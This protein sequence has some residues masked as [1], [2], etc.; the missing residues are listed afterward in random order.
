MAVGRFNY[1]R[2]KD[3]VEKSFSLP[4]A[5]ANALL[6]GP[7]TSI[8]QQAALLLGSEGVMLGFTAGGGTPLYLTSVND[9]RPTECMQQWCSLWFD[10]TARLAA[11]TLQRRRISIID[12]AYMKK[13]GKTFRS[14]SKPP[15]RRFTEMGAGF[16][17]RCLSKP[18]A[19]RSSRV[20][21]KVETGRIGPFMLSENFSV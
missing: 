6:L 8:T 4:Y 3:A 15:T 5:N 13:F 19:R 21:R 2:R 1:V 16:A 12:A 10:P 17:P 11:K 20:I 7:G 14:Y 18:P 9:S